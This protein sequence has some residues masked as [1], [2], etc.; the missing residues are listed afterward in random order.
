MCAAWVL[1]FEACPISWFRPYE[2]SQHCQMEKSDNNLKKIVPWSLQPEAVQ[3][4][5]GTR[6][7]VG[8]MVLRRGQKQTFSQAGAHMLGD[9]R[10]I[11]PQQADSEYWEVAFRI[12]DTRNFI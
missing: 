2:R 11:R 1:L 6:Q 7:R 10:A 5:V 8:E 4:V 12:M 9:Q 3:L